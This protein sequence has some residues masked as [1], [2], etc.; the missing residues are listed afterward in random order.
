MTTAEFCMVK[1][2]AR[3]FRKRSLLLC[4]HN[5]VVQC[6]VCVCMGGG[7]QFPFVNLQPSRLSPSAEAVWLLS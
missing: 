7:V 4:I 5:Y 3:L 1:I 6:G 2:T